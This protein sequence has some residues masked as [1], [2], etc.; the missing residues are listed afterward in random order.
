MHKWKIEVVEPSIDDLLGDE[1]MVPV[2]RSAGLSAEEFRLQ[3]RR[4][5]CDLA[6]RQQAGAE[7]SACCQAH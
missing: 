3:I 7:H 2:M 6:H 4:M 5:A 1:I